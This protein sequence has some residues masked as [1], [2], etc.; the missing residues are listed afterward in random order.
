MV[1]NGFKSFGRRTELLFGPSFNVVLGPNGS[2]KSNILDGLCFVLGK[3]S[4]KS[5][6]AEKS[7]NLLYNGG[8]SK[9]Q[10]KSGEV[11][12]F[13]DNTHQTF[14]TTD[15]TVKI[16]RIIKENGQSIYRV[17]DQT[18][19]RQQILDLLSIARINPDG[20]NIILQGD[21]V[22]LV[23]MS[24]IERRMI[25]EEI[26]GI[27]IY[28]EKKQKALLEMEKVDLRLNEAE[29][30][31][32][33]RK[34]YLKDLKK[35]RDQAVKYK[36]LNDKIKQ[37]KASYLKRKID[38]KISERNSIQTKIDKEN[39]H[40]A[41]LSIKISKYREDIMK[42]RE[43]IR[44]I[45][46]DMEK[47]GEREQIL[48]Q[49]E[50]ETL[51]VDL[52]T[53]KTRVSSIQNEINRIAIR[54]QQLHKNIED[55]EGRIA[56]I[57]RE[58]EEQH[59]RQ[60][61]LTKQRDELLNK[62][63][64]FKKKNKIDD[65][66]GIEK[67]I[68]TIDTQIDSKQKEVSELREAQQNLLREKD[69]L[70]FTIQSVDERIAKVIEIE[71]E[72]ES[73]IKRLKGM[74]DEFKKSTVELNALLNQD[75]SLAATIGAKRKRLFEDKERLASL[76]VRNADIKETI[77][78]N[79]AVTKILEHK[80]KF[81]EVHGT[82]ADLGK[83]KSMYSL[84]LETAAG[85]RIKGIVVKDDAVASRCIHFLK[86]NKF[87]SAAFFPLNKVKGPE[88]ESALKKLADVKGVH[89]LATDLLTFE[90]A[91]KQVIHYVFGNTLVIDNI[92]VARRIGIG[93]ARMV[94]LDGDLCETSGVMIGGYRQ[95]KRGGGFKEQELTEDIDK[96]MASTATLEK[97]M[98]S[99]EIQKQENELRIARLRELKASL[100][101]EIIKTEKSLHLDSGDL[102][103][104][105]TLKEELKKKCTETDKE[106]RS[107]V[108]KISSLN[109]TF[110]DLK[111]EKEK[112]RTFI[113][114]LK[115]PMVLAELNAFEQKRL[116]LGNQI[117]GIESD[118]KNY[119]LQL[120]DILK[121]DKENSSKIIKDLDK[122]ELDFQK[123]IKDL[124]AEITNYEKAVQNKEHEVSKFY[125]K[126]KE[127]YEKRTKLNTE[128]SAAENTRL[129]VEEDSRKVEFNV[130]TFSLE[131]A[132]V[133]AE[134]SG[135]EEEF[136]QYHGIELD[137][138]KPE[139]ELKSEIA[140]FEKMKDSIGSVNLRALE[141][142]DLVEREFNSIIEKKKTL[143]E[144][145]GSVVS[146]MEEIEGKKIG[147]F[148]KTFNAVNNH[149][150]E[151]FGAITTKGA[152]AELVLDNFEK[153]FEDGMRIMV[154]LTGTKFLDL[155]SLSGGEKTLTALAFLFAIQDYEPASFYLLDEVDAALDKDNSDKLS[156]LIRKYCEK[157][158]YIVI[159]HNDALITEADHLFGVSMDEHG[160]SKTV[161]LKM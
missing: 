122:E 18:R 93:K 1:L 127:L 63:N 103:A 64:S 110:A 154:K 48:L 150:K 97:E 16:T 52:A 74:R 20:Y 68:E 56:E 116:E 36:E 132:K 108:D 144:E 119:D 134:L 31:L 111:M 22:S 107:V 8:K 161:S 147:E 53:K 37:N 101:G 10:A 25:I 112:L 124:T 19:T 51:R 72:H 135:L 106:L 99:L 133:K 21:I 121:R 158:Q 38:A 123:E 75:S 113:K 151:I 11:S 149:F 146:L 46:E 83:V 15:E 82:V 129:N 78:G 62:I 145:R 96:L 105:K 84:A 89:G 30:I 70:E 23:E 91:F 61:T 44:A 58:K 81:G 17:N 77:G 33:E 4:S 130:N 24:T 43:E 67:N 85:P 90:P 2:G 71:K 117:I 41:R 29:I 109:R 131:N 42:R 160:I 155:R 142:Y 55:V 3:S 104:S 148:M 57:R 137:V 26:A 128:I 50:L 34:A 49:K 153:P 86:D 73:D 102:D 139:D 69:R 136:L 13:F 114:E 94:T 66:A 39:E 45:D 27:G 95:R 80:N 159:S 138:R 125:A 115:N 6:R 141:V 14:P 156:N 35:D 79:L 92:E 5:L 47:K 54:K 98:K 12:I 65:E 157:A 152:E 126:S 7:S 88:P 120:S 40:L 87:G 76:E 60:T 143:E 118:I 100:E 9:N 28:E 32:K 59:A 140:E